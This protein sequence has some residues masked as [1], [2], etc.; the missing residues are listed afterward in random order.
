M[1]QCNIL[2]GKGVMRPI[3]IAVLLCCA[4]IISVNAF[5]QSASAPQ[6]A[7]PD[8]DSA[9]R[10]GGVSPNPGPSLT[11]PGQAAASPG[12]E[13]KGIATGSKRGTD[14][15]I[16]SMPAPDR[17]APIKFENGIFVYPQVF[18]G[19]GQNDNV[20]GTQTDKISSSI[21]NLQ[22]GVVAELKNNGD[23]YSASYTGNYGA[24]GSSSDDD[25]AHHE[26]Q[27]AGDNYFTSRARMGWLL[28]YQ[29]ETDARGSTDRA[30]STEPDKWHAP[31]LRGR[32]I[33]GG[34]SAIGRVEVDVQHMQKRYD[35]NRGFTASSELDMTEL[36]GRFYY[37]VAPRTLVLAE[38]RNND[39]EYVSNTPA[40]SVEQRYYLGATWEA[41]A[42]TTGIF[43][44]G[45]LRKDFDAD[46]RQDFT[47]FSW[48]GTIRWQPTKFSVVDIE[49]SKSTADPT[50]VGNFTVHSGLDAVWQHKWTSYVTSKVILGSLKSDYDGADRV[51]TTRNYGLGVTY[52]V[53]RW[54][55][56]G[57][58]W[59]YT[60]RRSNND[61]FE[62]KR[63]VAMF[64]AEATL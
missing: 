6:T 16:L 54:L 36:A 11:A 24:Y 8:I 34:E 32:F 49:T 40:N 4:G 5:A 60:D 3:S 25:F 61:T 62:F 31:M 14:Q 45:Q 2:I 56:I 29:Q 13:L 53:L 39:I 41:T 52:D 37:R 46:S 17:G 23:R 33:Y 43:K 27:V 21:V 55:S 30:I 44:L 12:Y 28:G 51:D 1:L 50:G 48:E 15:V 64:T 57:A 59:A 63:N 26:L 22:P 47:G 18:L 19:V 10:L 20:I 35:N 9:Y 7:T 42:S 38:I 58:D